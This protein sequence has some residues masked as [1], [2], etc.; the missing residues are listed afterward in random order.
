M[1]IIQYC[2]AVCI[3][4]TVTYGGIIV[5]Y[6]VKPEPAVVPDSQVVPLLGFP[7]SMIGRHNSIVLLLSTHELATTSRLPLYPCWNQL[8]S[9]L[10]TF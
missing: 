5:M 8:L 10:V 7:L 2:I 1:R 3:G 9:S 6:S 4:I